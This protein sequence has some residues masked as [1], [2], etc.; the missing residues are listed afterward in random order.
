MY[1]IIGNCYGDKIN[2]VYVTPAYALGIYMA[3]VEKW[4]PSNFSTEA[5][6]AGKDVFSNNLPHQLKFSDAACIKI[7]IE[8]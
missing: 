4:F 6:S 8:N 5:A 3:Y 1:K 2:D 7:I